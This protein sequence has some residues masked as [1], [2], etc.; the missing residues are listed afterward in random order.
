MVQA[1]RHVQGNSG[2]VCAVCAT[3]MNTDTYLGTNLRGRAVQ[4]GRSREGEHSSLK[5]SSSL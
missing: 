1:M 2:P 3:L 5:M 4:R